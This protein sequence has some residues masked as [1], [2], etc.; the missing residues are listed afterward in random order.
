MVFE[1]FSFKR[2][3]MVS[4]DSAPFVL[5]RTAINSL[6]TP[7]GYILP[8]ETR[9]V[10]FPNVREERRF[11]LIVFSFPRLSLETHHS[12]H[13]ILFSGLM[14][15]Y[16]ASSGHLPPPTSS[17]EGEQIHRL[18]GQLFCTCVLCIVLVCF[19]CKLPLKSYLCCSVVVCVVPMK[20]SR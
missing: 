11:T 10:C 3:P 15:D 4:R 12:V 19:Y 16:F 17:Q 9:A 13:H 6:T 20:T 7:R 5:L 1:V 8:G 14:S 18:Q 2:H